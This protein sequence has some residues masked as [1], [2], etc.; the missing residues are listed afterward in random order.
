MPKVLTVTLSDIEYEILKRIKI[1][2][3]EDGEKL[4][5]LLRLYIFTIPELKSS[6][7]ALKRVEQK[8]QIEEILRDIWAAYELTDNPTETWKDD[9]INKLRNDLIEINVLMN[10][11]DKAFIPTNKLRSLFKMLLHDIA[12]EKKDV[13]EYSVAC[14]ATI[15][16]LM[17]F[18]AGS[19]P[20]ET[21]R[22]GV[23]LLN[24]GWLF[25]YA[26]A[27]KNAREFIINKKL[28]SENPVPVPKVS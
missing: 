12:T 8:E 19:L 14:V 13:D 24:E 28:H 22:D 26:T 1:V 27:M 7:Y 2:E 3:G 16:L 4:R 20:K 17:E 5:N 6:E 15:Q 10:T 25:V 9:K 11:G 18:G 21:I 23:I